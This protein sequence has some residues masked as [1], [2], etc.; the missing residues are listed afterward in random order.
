MSD[1][2]SYLLEHPPSR[3]HI[4]HARGRILDQV[5]GSLVYNKMQKVDSVALGSSLSGIFIRV[6]HSETPGFWLEL[7]ISKEVLE[8]F[9]FKKEESKAASESN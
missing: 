2:R 5:N 3:D 6:D 7:E 9:G 1:L 4:I 8:R